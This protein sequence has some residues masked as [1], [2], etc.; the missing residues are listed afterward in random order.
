[1]A[2]MFRSLIVIGSECIGGGGQNDQVDLFCAAQL[3]ETEAPAPAPHGG[4]RPPS[5]GSAN[6]SP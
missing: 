6:Y 3:I 2:L 4:Y 1:V 5:G